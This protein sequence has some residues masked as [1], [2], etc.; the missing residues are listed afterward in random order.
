MTLLKISNLTWLAAATIGL[1]A[2]GGGGGGGSSSS[3]APTA[4]I[5]SLTA[6]EAKAVT[7]ASVQGM[8]L[9]FD[10]KYSSFDSNVWVDD[11]DPNHTPNISYTYATCNS[12]TISVLW[13]D[14]NG[15]LSA[16]DSVAVSFN[17]CQDFGI[18]TNGTLVLNPTTIDTSSGYDEAGSVTADVDTTIGATTSNLTANG[19]YG[20]SFMSGSFDETCTYSGSARL[21]PDTSAPNQFLEMTNFVGSY[22][23]DGG[24]GDETY[25][26]N[27]NLSIPTG[28]GQQTLAVETTTPLYIASADQ[29]PSAAGQTLTGADDQTIVLADDP[30]P[31]PASD[32][33]VTYPLGSG[34]QTASD[35]WDNYGF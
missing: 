31:A 1:S 25:D 9:L 27:Y 24:S 26:A 34:T 23:F 12:G 22:D 10:Q 15:V 28:A 16:G 17:A 20:Y 35:Q 18:T 5:S 32:V 21:V 4:D 7:Q 14:N 30:D 19:N 6:A 29:Y 8:L 2:C 3:S 13:T 11:S 33:N